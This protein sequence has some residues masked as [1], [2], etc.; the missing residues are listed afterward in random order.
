MLIYQFNST[1]QLEG[2]NTVNIPY[3]E[4]T[5]IE[6][7]RINDTVFCIVNK[8]GHIRKDSLAN[9][10]YIVKSITGLIWEHF[11]LKNSKLNGQYILYYEDG[12]IKI[13]ENYVEGKKEGGITKYSYTGK[14][15]KSG[16][17]KENK[18]IGQE[19]SYWLNGKIARI[20]I[21]TENS[22]WRGIRNHYNK[23]G[24]PI[25]EEEFNKLS[26]EK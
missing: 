5:P 23:N 12:K 4:I 7:S 2:Y 10:I 21:R 1:A 24:I 15:K 3:E 19:Y 14:I 20:I 13:I 11:S 26:F 9:G 6:V 22:D 25:S 8:Y 17:I 16:Y 18:F